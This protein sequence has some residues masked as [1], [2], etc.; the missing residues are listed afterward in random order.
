MIRIRSK[1][2]LFRRCGMAHSK[3]P[4]D[5]ADDFFTEE[6][7]E[8]LRAES[9]L[10]VELISEE[11]GSQADTEEGQE[12]TDALDTSAEEPAGEAENLEE[13]SEPGD[14]DLEA[15]VKEALTEP[16]LEESP[17]GSDEELLIEAAKQVIEAGKVTKEEKPLVE[18]MEEILGHEISAADRDQAFEAIRGNQ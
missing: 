14:A 16:P 8:I 2:H 10:I 9:T 3:E 15:A 17:Q 13:E 18:A 5:Y 7:L 4:V 6:Q 12:G 11:P 1:R